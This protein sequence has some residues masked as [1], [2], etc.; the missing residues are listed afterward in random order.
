MQ[1]IIDQMEAVR[2]GAALNDR[3]SELQS[4]HNSVRTA[5][6]E[7]ERLLS[8]NQA[9]RAN[10]KARRFYSILIARFNASISA[11]RPMRRVWCAAKCSE[12]TSSLK[13]WSP[14]AELRLSVFCANVVL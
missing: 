8:D 11:M 7:L 12:P 13:S 14:T 3:Y 6:G 4:V 5:Q 1:M 2:I 9:L 10:L